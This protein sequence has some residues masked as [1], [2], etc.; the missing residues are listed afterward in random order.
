MN[1]LREALQIA[2]KTQFDFLIAERLAELLPKMP[3]RAVECLSMMVEGDGDGLDILGWQ[4]HART[5]LSVAVESDDLQARTLAVE[6]IHR[7]GARGHPEFAD[8]LPT[9]GE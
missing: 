3:A 8:L 2:G 4:E 5:I 1:Q 7:L 6:L 9:K